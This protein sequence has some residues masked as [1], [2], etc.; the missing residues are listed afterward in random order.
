MICVKAY[1]S[2]SIR[3]R[4]G[5]HASDDDI[6]ENTKLGIAHAAEIQARFGTMLDLYVPHAHDTIVQLLWRSGVI[7]VDNILDADCAIIE[8]CDFMIVD[9]FHS[10]GVRVE[11]E[12]CEAAG[13]PIIY[14]SYNSDGDDRNIH[15]L[16]NRLLRKKL[17]DG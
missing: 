4:L 15:D 9:G 7:T 8:T 11:I 17:N 13:T 5:N 3:G 10:D 14:L 1:Y 6:R 12:Y 2:A 16:I